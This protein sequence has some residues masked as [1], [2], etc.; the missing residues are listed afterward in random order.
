MDRLS[1][2]A[3]HGKGRRKQSF[4]NGGDPQHR[5]QAQGTASSRKRLA[6]VTPAA[7]SDSGF[8]FLND[9]AYNGRLAGYPHNG[10][11]PQ[12]Q[13]A[14]PNTLNSRQVAEAPSSTTG[15][16]NSQYHTGRTRSASQ[17]PNHQT[18][19][20]PRAYPDADGSGHGATSFDSE[21]GNANQHTFLPLPVRPNSVVRNR[22]TT[23]I[24]GAQDTIPSASPARTRTA[25][26]A[27]MHR[28]TSSAHQDAMV[29]Q[30]KNHLV[31]A[32]Q[33]R[34]A[35]HAT[36]ELLIDSYEEV[37]KSYESTLQDQVHFNELCRA[38]LESQE[39]L[40][41]RLQQIPAQLAEQLR[42]ATKEDKGA[43]ERALQAL[44][45][46]VLRP[47]F[48][49]I[50]K[51]LRN[52]EE[53][54]D[55]D[56]RI[57]ETRQS[58][59]ELSLQALQTSVCEQVDRVVFVCETLA[60]NVR[61]ARSEERQIY[62]REIEE[63]QHA[64][65]SLGVKKAAELQTSRPIPSTS[66]AEVSSILS[67]QSIGD[68]ETE[69]DRTRQRAMDLAHSSS[70]YEIETSNNMLGREA[71]KEDSL[72]PRAERRE[73]ATSQRRQASKRRPAP[74]L[75][76]PL[77]EASEGSLSSISPLPTALSTDVAV[78]AAPSKEAPVSRTHVQEAPAREDAGEAISVEKTHAKE[79][80]P[81]GPPAKKAPAKK[82]ST[83]EASAP[84]AKRVT[85]KYGSRS[86]KEH[87]PADQKDGGDGERG[88]GPSSR[89]DAGESLVSED[90]ASSPPPELPKRR[91]RKRK[92][93]MSAPVRS[94]S[95]S[96]DSEY[97]SRGL[98]PN[99]EEG[100][101]AGGHRYS[102]RAR[103]KVPK[104]AGVWF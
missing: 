36:V 91:G 72:P 8:H 20:H 14:A 90:R 86:K 58:K 38:A 61:E 92:G 3:N 68:N 19:S 26:E 84:P 34:D 7:S 53:S 73:E 70:A 93:P 95:P 55:R 33:A 104:V 88:E 17:T 74:P 24:S 40:N 71:R 79:T 60:D 4:S 32:K 47:Q 23:D 28:P 78:A 83:K 59:L 85:K 67:P 89:R 37:K 64:C 80:Q 52:I 15:F 6:Q 25:P 62:Q 46:S 99:V 2:Q 96:S 57:N 94:P 30:M 16:P 56:R 35:T 66:P 75:E 102:T 49:L 13:L 44:E 12:A 65:S 81:H 29:V 101:A 50:S 87:L 77:S 31:E 54:A 39:T 10:L 5:Y 27:N 11:Q 76:S 45:T 69:H 9:T 42:E 18:R 100:S 82:A 1:T 103:G 48:E 51:A 98:V 43:T 41:Q 21:S 97:V 22:P 63:R